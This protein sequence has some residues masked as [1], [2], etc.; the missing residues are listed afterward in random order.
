MPTGS[1]A[2]YS[3]LQSNLFV[4]INIEEY[5]TTA[6][7]S[8]SNT[9]LRFSDNRD[10]FTINGENYL[11]L[12]NLMSVTSSSSELRVSSGELTIV[13]SGIPDSSIAEIIHSRIK[14]SPVI[15]YRAFFNPTT[16]GTIPITG[17]FGRFVGFVN[18]YSIQEEYD[19]DSRTATNTLALI[20]NSS[21]DVLQN[22]ITGRRTNPRSQKAFY[23]NDLAMDR[24]PTLKNATF[25]FGAKK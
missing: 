20:C 19:V 5:R 15:V 12:G 7:G 25:D 17:P 18:N 2:S 13:I 3:A 9:V 14:G 23:P 1:F 21:V 24:V 16:G 4:R 22:K 6:G 11:G 8:Y 10:N